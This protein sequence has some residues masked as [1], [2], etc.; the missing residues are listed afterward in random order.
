MNQSA[1]I[2][3]FDTADF[4]FG[5]AS[6]SLNAWTSSAESHGVGGQFAKRSLPGEDT[7]P[8][9]NNYS[10][11]VGAV[12]V[13]D[14]VPVVSEFPMIQRHSALP[15]KITSRAKSQ[16][17]FMVGMAWMPKRLRNKIS[18][19]SMP[20]KRSLSLVLCPI[21]SRIFFP[22]ALTPSPLLTTCVGESTFPDDPA[23]SRGRSHRRNRSSVFRPIGKLSARPARRMSQA[24]P[25]PLWNPVLPL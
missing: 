15:H 23:T 14:V 21:E 18:G 12:Q 16:T 19:L 20:V 6:D 2:E 17:R 5:A 3:G 8:Y 11:I 22:E 24:P 9:P 25:S 7:V 1:C 4:I 10:A 13:A